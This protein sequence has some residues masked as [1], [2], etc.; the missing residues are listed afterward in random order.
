MSLR[1]GATG[2]EVKQLQTWL[3]DNGADLTVDGI[4]G[5][6]TE[7]ALKSYQ[8]A[9]GLVADGIAGPK[10]YAKLD[11]DKSGTADGTTDP[12]TVTAGEGSDLLLPERFVLWYNSDTG[13]YW[14]VL[15]IPDVTVGDASAVGIITGWRIETDEDLEAILGPGVEPSA[16]FVGT[17]ADFTEKG[18]IDLGGAS[19]LRPFANIEADPFD[20]WV[21]DL[22]VLAKVKPWLLDEDYIA[23]AVQASM[24]RADGSISLEELQT[25]QWWIK[26][27]PGERAWMETFHGDPAAAQQILEDNRA[28]M[29]YRLAQAGID[30]ASD[31]LI[32][33]MADKA[34]MGT[35]A[36]G[37]LEGQIAALSDP[38]S[39]DVMDDELVQFL[40]DSDYE[41][42]ELD[43]TFDETDTVRDLLREW[44]GPVFGDWDEE[45]IAAKAGELRN[46]PDAKIEFIESLKDQRMAM[47][48]GYTD[49]SVS[50]AAAARPWTSWLSSQWGTP[51]IDETDSV[52]QDILQMNNVTEAGKLARRT[53]FERGYDKVIA[54]TSNGL[55]AAMRTGTV[56]AV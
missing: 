18:L 24:E 54:D 41:P 29:R 5:P 32:N 53:G 45:A 38:Y 27:N 23:L 46:N 50:Y 33:F 7:S 17:N 43:Q 28:A 35:W 31:E 20:T 19:E 44:L 6:K 1:R 14:V 39:V 9:N 49:R 34:T 2:A 3:N 21:E 10:T 4:F 48:P 15:E 16:V 56:G 42:G 22:T 8:E 13:E 36:E 11:P 55:R 26:H 40:A 37:K 30:N 25:T 47:M 12:D 51:N 52:F